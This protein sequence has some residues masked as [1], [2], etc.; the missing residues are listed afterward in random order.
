MRAGPSP[1][2]PPVLSIIIP[3]L[4]EAEG[5]ASTLAALAPLRARGAEVVVV[6]GGSEDATVALA[7]PLAD[8][9]LVAARGRALQMNAGAKAARGDILLFLHADCRLPAHADALITDGLH[10]ARKTWGRFDVTLVGRSVLLRVVGT[11][12][13]GRSR[14]TGVSTGDQGLFVTRSLFEAAGQFPRIPLMEDVAITRHLKRFS[15]P[16]NLRHRM[17][18]SGRR[19]EKHGVLRTVLLMWRLRFQY[20]RGADPADLARTYAPHKS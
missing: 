17:Q 3:C 14:L 10:R 1:S 18:V 16:L 13:N 19:W 6:D 15:A 2:P 5:I 20:W 9:V 8:Q 4:N 12:M 7:R 11:L